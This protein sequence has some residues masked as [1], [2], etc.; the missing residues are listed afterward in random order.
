MPGIESENHVLHTLP[1]RDNSTEPLAGESVEQAQGTQRTS[2]CS[3]N[4]LFFDIQEEELLEFERKNLRSLSEAPL[5][6]PSSSEA[7]TKLGCRSESAGVDWASSEDERSSTL[8]RL[9]STSHTKSA[10]SSVITISDSEDSEPVAPPPPKKR[11]H[12]PPRSIVSNDHGAVPAT[13]AISRSQSTKPLD[14]AA[15]FIGDLV[16]EAWST[17]K[18]KGHIRPGELLRLERDSLPGKTSSKS[19]SNTVAALTA[20]AKKKVTEDAIVRVVNT[21]GSGMIQIFTRLNC[22]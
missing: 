1:P 21:R 9:S 4:N 16:I 14:C 11:K 22:N 19:T 13:S 3:T 2:E 12:T 17:V 6:L 20:A 7:T 15:L 8:P 18:G 10:P 5:F